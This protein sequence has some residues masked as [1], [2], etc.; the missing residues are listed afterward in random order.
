MNDSHPVLVCVDGSASTAAA[1]RYGA[2]VALRLDRPLELLHVA[3]DYLPI[4]ALAPLAAPLSHES[5]QAIGEKILADAEVLSHELLDADRVSCVLHTGDRGHRIVEAAQGATIVVLGDDREP[6][7]DHLAFGSLIAEVAS[8]AD[9]PVVTVP[10]G[11]AEP[12]SET[13]PAGERPSRRILLGI[14]DPRRVPEDLMLRAFELAHRQLAVLE[15]VH[16]WDMAQTYGE[17]VASLID[18]PGWK[19]MVEDEIDASTTLA[20]AAYPG[21]TVVT[22]VAYGRPA[23]V[24]RELSRHADLVLVAR[25]PHDVIRHLGSTGRSLLR[26]VVCPVEVL[27][28]I[29]RSAAP[30]DGAQ[31]DERRAVSV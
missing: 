22:T 15:L 20:R 13:T 9:V 23:R 31:S 26:S 10:A 11:W 30:Q 18:F 16:V 28:V 6:A 24:L 1:V 8:A 14:K 12:V 21:V 4:A 25:R 2:V 27:P 5:F 3:P 19:A 29:E 17:V 7:F